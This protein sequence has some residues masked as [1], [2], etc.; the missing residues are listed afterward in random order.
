MYLSTE[1]VVVAGSGASEVAT[2]GC[3]SSLLVSDNWE[4]LVGSPAG[5]FVVRG[6]QFVL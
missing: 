2:C 1:D 4:G 6:F 5:S 3:R